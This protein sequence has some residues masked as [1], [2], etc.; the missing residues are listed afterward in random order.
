MLN[1]VSENH[2]LVLRELK[3]CR[4]MFERHHSKEDDYK[5]IIELFKKSSQEIAHLCS[6][7]EIRTV[8]IILKTKLIQGAKISDTYNDIIDNLNRLTDLLL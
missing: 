1:I 8:I 7:T 5:G 4:E 6:K 2:I 3:K